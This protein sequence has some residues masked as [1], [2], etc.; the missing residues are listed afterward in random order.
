MSKR[1]GEVAGEEVQVAR[2]GNKTVEVGRAYR[3]AD[4]IV[5]WVTHRSTRG[6]YHL[7]WLEEE[8]NVWFEGGKMKDGD[9]TFAAFEEAEIHSAPRPGEAYTKMGVYGRPR[10]CRVPDYESREE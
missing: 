4:G 1:T 7:L 2:T 6:Y 10:E 9:A 8:R 3:C 5:R